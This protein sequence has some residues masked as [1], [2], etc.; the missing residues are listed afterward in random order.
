MGPAKLIASF[1]QISFFLVGDRFVTSCLLKTSVFFS[2]AFGPEFG[3][4]GMF[5]GL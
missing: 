4:I 1:L 5:C 3:L 2:L